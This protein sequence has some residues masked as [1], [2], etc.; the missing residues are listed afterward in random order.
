M[1][2]Q[3]KCT[4]CGKVFL[5]FKSG[6]DYCGRECKTKAA[7]AKVKSGDRNLSL[8]EITLAADAENMSYGKF[9]ELYKL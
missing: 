9:T 4:I 8:E 7:I 6:T 3:K 5:G 1:A 2:I